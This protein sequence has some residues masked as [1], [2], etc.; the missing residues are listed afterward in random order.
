MEI[1]SSSSE[2]SKQKQDFLLLLGKSGH[3]YAY[4]DG[5]IERYL[6][7]YQSRSPPSLPKEIMVKIPFFDSSIT[8][9]KFIAD[10]PSYMLS[11]TDEVT[12]YTT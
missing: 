10:N 4:D 11:S 8:V 12:L 2:Q 6:L 1:I 3:V 7:Q 9:V 5:Q